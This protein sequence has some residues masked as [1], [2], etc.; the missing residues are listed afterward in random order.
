MATTVSSDLYVQ[1]QHFYARQM[2]ALDNGRIE[3]YANTFT[4]DGSFQ[5]TP[6]LDPVVG[7]DAILE[8]L[9]SF[10]K[11]YENDPTQRRHYF[12]QIVL[13][14]R[15]DG[16]IGSTVYALIVRVKPN[17]QPEIWPSTVVHDVIDVTD[18]HILLKS[19]SVAYDQLV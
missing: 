16:T 5:H 2:Q 7:P 6:G 14:P 8:E 1:V 13:D 11:K 10:L 18:G 3:E 12:N 15:D 17:E 4:K 9:R 19:R